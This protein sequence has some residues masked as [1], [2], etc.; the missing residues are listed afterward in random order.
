MISGLCGAWIITIPLGP[1]QKEASTG[2]AQ[3]LFPSGF[4]GPGW[5]MCS[6]GS[7]DAE[8]P[9][10]GLTLLG[11]KGKQGN[12]C[13]EMYWAPRTGERSLGWAW[14]QECFLSSPFRSGFG[15]SSFGRDQCGGSGSLVQRLWQQLDLA[16]RC[17]TSVLR[18]SVP[19]DRV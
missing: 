14:W 8:T 6:L 17:R 7:Q 12:S 1:A 13:H 19:G 10:W 9:E 4:S 18:V 5:Y 15:V 3:V 2:C 11:R 16:L